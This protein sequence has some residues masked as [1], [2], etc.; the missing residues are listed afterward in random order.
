MEV[1]IS[2]LFP[3]LTKVNLRPKLIWTHWN[4]IKKYN[5]R[6]SFYTFFL[7]QKEG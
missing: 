2:H 5:V 6:V 1:Y 4:L 7:M 3:T